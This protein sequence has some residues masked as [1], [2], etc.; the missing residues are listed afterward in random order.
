MSL[1]GYKYN[2]T[3]CVMRCDHRYHVISNYTKPT[4]QNSS[5][6][7]IENDIQNIS[8][9]IEDR[10][11]NLGYGIGVA[12]NKIVF[13][14]F[15]TASAVAERLSA[16]FISNTTTP[17]GENIVPMEY[18]KI[19]LDKS[20]TLSDYPKAIII[21]GRAINHVLDAFFN[22]THTEFLYHLALR[23]SVTF[24]QNVTMI[25]QICQ[26]IDV[27]NEEEKVKLLIILGHG[28][29]KSILLD[30]NH[31]DGLIS[32]ENHFLDSIPPSQSLNCLDKLDV[33]AKIIL[34]SCNTAGRY[35]HSILE[36]EQMN[37]HT[38]IAMHA[39]QRQVF[40]PK[41]DLIIGTLQIETAPKFEVSAH[42]GHLQELSSQFYGAGEHLTGFDYIQ[43]YWENHGKYRAAYRLED[44]R[45]D[46]YFKGNTQLSLGKFEVITAEPATACGSP[47]SYHLM[48]E[49]CEQEGLRPS[50]E[51]IAACKRSSLCK[52]IL[53][54]NKRIPSNANEN[55]HIHHVI[56]RQTRKPKR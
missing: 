47:M 14:F 27:G 35:T 30:K 22:R 34:Y 18:R 7:S 12:I 43:Y 29:A 20:K 45:I 54:S 39:P 25:S 3:S 21:Q 11:N 2:A 24:F 32:V 31:P 13:S 51:R 41:F 42:G 40:A 55:Q 46:S 17:R 36:A 56:K 26:A 10:V 5:D 44:S 15:S 1:I 19:L 49:Q 4:C 16:F 53:F 50:E 33:N 6:P 8:Q 28:N 38:L 9:T 37:V 48:Q 52:N 23:Y